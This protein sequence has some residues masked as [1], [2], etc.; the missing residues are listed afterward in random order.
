MSKI[1]TGS[2]EKGF[3]FRVNLMAY[4]A[5]HFWN[6]GALVATIITQ[7][8]FGPTCFN[9]WIVGQIMGRDERPTIEDIADEQKYMQLRMVH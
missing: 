4:T 1:S 3:S 9:S 2:A 8:G 6:A 5:G 7:G